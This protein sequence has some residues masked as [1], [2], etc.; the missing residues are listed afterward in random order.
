MDLKQTYCG[1]HFT[2]CI[3]IESCQAPGTNKM[4]KVLNVSYI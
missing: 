4:L 1:D 2:I 3:Y